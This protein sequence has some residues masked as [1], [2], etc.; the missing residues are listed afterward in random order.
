[1][2]GRPQHMSELAHDPARLKLRESPHLQSFNIA[3]ASDGMMQTPRLEPLQF[4]QTMAG[5]LEGSPS[6]KSAPIYSKQ[7]LVGSPVMRTITNQSQTTITTQSPTHRS[8]FLQHATFPSQFRSVSPL[9]QREP[10]QPN[11]SRSIQLSGRMGGSM[12]VPMQPA[13]TSQNYHHSNSTRGPSQV[14]APSPVS[15]TRSPGPGDTH[16]ITTN[17]QGGSVAKSLQRAS[18]TDGRMSARASFTIPRKELSSHRQSG[19]R[20]SLRQSSSKDVAVGHS[21]IPKT[22]GRKGARFVAFHHAACRIQRAWRMSRWR[23][24]FINFSR[25]E[26]GW[27]GTLDWLQRHNLLYGTELADADDIKWW[28]QQREGAPLDKEVDPWGCKKLHEHLQRVWYGRSADEMSQE[29]ILALQQAQA[30]ALAM[31][32]KAM[33][34]DANQIREFCIQNGGADSNL[35]YGQ[36][37]GT[38][39]HR[40]S[41]SQMSSSILR[42]PVST[43][44]SLDLQNI[45]SGT[46]VAGAMASSRGSFAH[47][48]TAASPIRMTTSLS[49]RRAA[50]QVQTT[51]GEVTNRMTKSQMSARQ[52]TIYQASPPQTHRA[53]RKSSAAS[54]AIPTSIASSLPFNSL[55]SVCMADSSVSSS[56]R[57][58]SPMAAQ[59]AQGSMSHPGLL[60]MSGG[61]QQAIASISRQPFS[62]RV[63]HAASSPSPLMARIAG[64]SY[65]GASGR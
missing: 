32:K 48:M 39:A 2:R 40:R 60:S 9:P 62:S 23:R 46:G 65:I 7:H 8:D 19:S 28:L 25:R 61:S 36:L 4:S 55:S 42:S 35:A 33:E 31:Q 50:T 6:P 56:V 24:S 14:S 47:V 16:G 15:R 11:P 10:S 52:H 30:Q 12:Q 5:L 54:A 57:A 20:R 3:Q 59:R 21:G 64:S 22:N 13:S 27:L 17:A 53:P 37:L 45:V 34:S 44:R 51:E 1:M 29:E 58:R 63:S 49:P 38:D 26:V 43:D 41:Y 18:K